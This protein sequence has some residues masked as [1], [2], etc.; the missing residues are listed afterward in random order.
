MERKISD[1]KSTLIK[2]ID[3]V[4][5]ENNYSASVE[6]R[7][8]DT[9]QQTDEGFCNNASVG[10]S[11]ASGSSHTCV[12]TAYVPSEQTTGTLEDRN[13]DTFRVS[14]RTPPTSSRTYL[15]SVCIP[16]E[17]PT[18]IVT[19]KVTEI[20]GQTVPVRITARA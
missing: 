5:S 13:C 4:S 11:A 14:R 10:T 3:E 20:T 2:L 19:E 1:L 6:H 18:E 8:S 16:S 15:K 7:Q 9:N 17:L 12:K